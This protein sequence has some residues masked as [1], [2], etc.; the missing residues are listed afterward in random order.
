MKMFYLI[1]VYNETA[2]LELLANNL[3]NSLPGEEKFYLFVDDASSDGTV[4]MLQRLF[5]GTSFHI[6]TKTENMGPGDSFNRGFEWILQNTENDK[7]MVITLEADNTSDIELVPVL[8]SISSLNYNLVLASVYAQGGG[9]QKS[10]FLR[11]LISFVANMFLRLVFS[12]KVQTLSSFFRLYHVGLLR[13]IKETYPAIISEKG[14]VCMFEILLK[15]VKVQARIIEVPT[16]L[17]S[18]NRKDRSKMK[19]IRTTG[20]YI[21]YTLK[22]LFK[23]L[24]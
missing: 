11:R 15:A 9:F 6:I 23:G 16:I 12:I 22:L 14:F 4:K 20:N 13:Q 3:K 8:V 10:S 17:K 1:P 18:Q 7:D 2:N 21:L 19:I 5:N 24:K